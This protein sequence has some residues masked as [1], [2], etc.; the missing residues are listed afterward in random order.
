[1][2]KKVVVKIELKSKLVNSRLNE[3]PTFMHLSI[4]ATNGG[5]KLIY[6]IVGRKNVFHQLTLFSIYY[7]E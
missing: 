3:V 6:S 5:D 7:K 2:I 1:M 4:K